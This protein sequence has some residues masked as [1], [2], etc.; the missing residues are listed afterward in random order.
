MNLKCWPMNVDAEISEAGVQFV[1]SNG[2]F[3]VVPWHLVMLNRSP[4]K[5]LII[6][7]EYLNRVRVGRRLIVPVVR[8]PGWKAVIEK[9]RGFQAEYFEDKSN[10]YE[11]AIDTRQEQR[12]L[13]V[14]WV[15]MF[16]AVAIYPGMFFWMSTQ[17][18]LDV[19]DNE[20]GAVY[21]NS[22]II[23][24]VC[25]GLWL[26]VGTWWCVNGLV[27]AVRSIRI[28]A[29]RHSGLLVAEKSGEKRE[30]PWESV[31]KLRSSGFG[32]VVSISGI[33]LRVHLPRTIQMRT[34]VRMNMPPGSK[35]TGRG[36]ALRAG[37][38]GLLIGMLASL[39]LSYMDIDGELPFSALVAI[40][41][42]PA[43]FASFMLWLNNLLESRVSERGIKS[44]D[45]RSVN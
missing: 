8:G 20:P 7:D 11:I 14:Q 15:M 21:R 6:Y 23:L 33:D 12:D 44:S 17:G 2:E 10:A 19:P 35:K 38:V 30:V 9:A 3:T 25:M 1:D 24:G 4:T 27:Q 42:L 18:A 5:I 45:E 29:V 16:I 41:V 22:M 34:I 37:A 36:L 26:L 32:L 40:A 28:L 31:S 39:W 13:L 43:I